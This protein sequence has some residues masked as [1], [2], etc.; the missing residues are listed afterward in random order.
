MQNKLCKIARAVDERLSGIIFVILVIA[1]TF[2][3]SKM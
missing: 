3:L 2:A 1:F